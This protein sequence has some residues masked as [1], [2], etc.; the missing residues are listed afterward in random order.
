MLEPGIK[1]NEGPVGQLLDETAR[2]VYMPELH[3]LDQYSEI[4]N[5]ARLLEY[6]VHVFTTLR[7]FTDGKV[8]PHVYSAALFNDVSKRLGDSI[9]G[10][11]ALRAF[12]TY[13]QWA[14]PD[15]WNFVSS[16]LS[17]VPLVE[18]ASRARR[19]E[20][21]ESDKELEKIL[22][23]TDDIEVP[24]RFWKAPSRIA[25]PNQML[26]LL[27][28]VNIESVLLESANM[29]H[30]LTH[31]ED[32][33]A[34]RLQDVF[35]TESFYAP[36]CEVLGYDGLS[37]ALRSRASLIRLT[38]SG[39][40]SSIADAK[41]ELSK[42]GSR[43]EVVNDVERLYN[44]VIDGDGISEPVVANRAQHAVVLGEALL[45]EPFIGISELR[46]VWRLKSKGSL[47]YK[48]ERKGRRP[49]DILGL[50]IITKTVNELAVAYGGVIRHTREHPDLEL[51]YTSQKSSPVPLPFHVRGSANYMKRVLGHP[52]VQAA[53]DESEVDPMPNAASGGF[54][55]AKL[56]TFYTNGLGEQVPVELQ[57][58]TERDRERS[59]V[60]QASHIMFKGAQHP[61]AP[62]FDPSVLRDIKERKAM[63]GR[64]IAIEPSKK[65]GAALRRQVDNA[66]VS[67]LINDN[68][69]SRTAAAKRR[70]R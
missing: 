70:Q 49:A 37:M 12:K 56:M 52:E 65:R 24:K 20:P 39:N 16:I 60:G 34:R 45:V 50:T 2:S 25:N 3:I 46:A 9:N 29:L 23:S 33:N 26:E 62:D 57:F 17:D 58:Q 35:D 36:I 21:G 32:P 7:D 31:A 69:A 66:H 4:S 8:D 42:F 44:G 48:F 63:I 6:P 11:N 55:V 53:L 61:A 47:A 43:E 38:E 59:R 54:Q 30:K 22:Q 27:Q 15:Q 19:F 67:I 13:S 68:K 18:E 64:H 14:S 41:N 10:K 1:F 40:K 28:G 51:N 5:D